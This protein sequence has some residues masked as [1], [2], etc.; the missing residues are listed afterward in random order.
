M[1]YR[2]LPVAG[3]RMISACNVSRLLR[4]MPGRPNLCWS[5]YCAFVFQSA[6]VK[7]RVGFPGSAVGQ[8]FPTPFRVSNAPGVSM[9]RSGGKLLI[10]MICATAI[11]TLV[12]LG[13]LAQGIVA[14][15]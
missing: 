10:L 3:A 2:S 4:I 9:K 1:R 6:V 15:G 7:A 12:S 14:L 13:V 11:F 8:V 5:P